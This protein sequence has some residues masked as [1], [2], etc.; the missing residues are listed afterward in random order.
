MIQNH[1]FYMNKAYQE[2]LRAF[3]NGEV[4]VGAVIIGPSGTLCGRG[5]NS[6]ER[7]QDATAHAEILAIGAAAQ[8]LGSWRLND[9]TLYVT[10]EPCMMCLG[11]ILNSRISTIVFGAT[12]PRLG[13]VVTHPFASTAQGAYNTFPAV[14]SGVLGMESSALLKSFF[15]NLRK[16]S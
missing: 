10:L 5:A 16:K 11:A 13:A 3:D 7:L 14:A 15:Q 8:S 1:E 2:A 4:P 9:C 6:M 12:D